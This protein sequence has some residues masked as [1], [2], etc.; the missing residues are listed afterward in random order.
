MRVLSNINGPV[1][2][3]FESVGCHQTPDYRC[4]I[5]VYIHTIM[6]SIKYTK[7]ALWLNGAFSAMPTFHGTV[8]HRF[9]CVIIDLQP[10]KDEGHQPCKFYYEIANIHHPKKQGTVK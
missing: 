4:D 7:R 3:G 9:H 8:P 6:L 1:E 2:H 5:S 10:D